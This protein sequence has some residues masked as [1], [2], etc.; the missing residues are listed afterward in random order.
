MTNETRP[1]GAPAQIEHLSGAIAQRYVTTSL[2]DSQ[3]LP[4]TRHRPDAST[5][6]TPSHRYSTQDYKALQNFQEL[7]DI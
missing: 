4:P 5:T 1:L 3:S 2:L 6:A 7:A